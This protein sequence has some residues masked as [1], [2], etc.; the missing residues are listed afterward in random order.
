[1]TKE[2]LRKFFSDFFCQSAFGPEKG[3]FLWSVNIKIFKQSLNANFQ[4]IKC[5]SCDIIGN[6][7]IDEFKINLCGSDKAK[8]L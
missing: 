3:F 8:Q 1:M 2:P 5:D 4:H 6:L 7:M